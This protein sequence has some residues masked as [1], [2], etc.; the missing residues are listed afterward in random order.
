MHT[1]RGLLRA[2]KSKIWLGLV[3]IAAIIALL[4]LGLTIGGLSFAQSE[5]ENGE[6]PSPTPPP[7]TAPEPEPPPSAVFGPNPGLDPIVSSL[8][9]VPTPY[10]GQSMF[11][12]IDLF[13]AYIDEE[14][15]AGRLPGPQPALG[16]ATKGTTIQVQDKMIQLPPDAYISGGWFSA[17]PPCDIREKDC[18]PV[19]NHELTRGD[20]TVWVSRVEGKIGRLNLA[21]GEEDA[22]DFLCQAVNG[23]P[24]PRP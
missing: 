4:A 20:S 11:D 6:S 1:T 14:E 12:W 15:K 17:D 13:N 10:P 9:N 19:P 8:P 23:V 2:L 21:P 16:P 18:I 5:S 3:P 22:F 7:V 24:C